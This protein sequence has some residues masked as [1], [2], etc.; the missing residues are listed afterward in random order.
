ME[1][2]NLTWPDVDIVAGTARVWHSKN[3]KPRTVPVRGPALE[4]LRDWR[5]RDG[6]SRMSGRVFGLTC[7][8]TRAWYDALDRAGISDFH[9]HDLRHSAASLLITAGEPLERIAR[10]LGHKSI[11]VT[12]RYAHLTDK[13]SSDAMDNMIAHHFARG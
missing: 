4:A 11:A 10:V 5:D 2:L 7:P 8:P 3:G 13:E 12:Q 9:F 1:L 6:V